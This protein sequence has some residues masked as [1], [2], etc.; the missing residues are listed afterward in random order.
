[1]KYH[2]EKMISEKE[3]KEKVKY[4]AD[5]INCDYQNENVLLVGI[6]KG[7]YMFLADLSRELNNV[8]E[9]DFMAVS[10]YGSSMITSGEIKILKDLDVN[11][12]NQHVLIIEDIIDT[13]FTLSKITKILKERNPKSLEVCT[14]LDKPDRRVVN[15][16]VKYVGIVIPDEYIVGYGIDFNQKYRTLKYIAKVVK[17]GLDNE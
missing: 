15:V 4:L 11:I 7:S 12:E 10:S 1:M 14:L 16:D 6:L 5:R 13:G 8:K 9:V 17:E 3:I 2:I